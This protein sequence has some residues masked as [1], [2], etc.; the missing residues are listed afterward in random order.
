MKHIK[1][2]KKLN[3]II[4]HIKHNKSIKSIKNYYTG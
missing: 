2:S 1:L 4:K 3:V